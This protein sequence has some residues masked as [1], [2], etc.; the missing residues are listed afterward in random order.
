[1]PSLL[2]KMR[3]AT[4]GEQILQ[5]EGRHSHLVCTPYKEK[6]SN[7]GLQLG[8]TAVTSHKSSLP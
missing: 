1:M 7:S 5:R 3:T 4:F 8:T 6:H 2:G